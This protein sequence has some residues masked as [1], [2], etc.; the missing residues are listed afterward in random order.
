MGD[1]MVEAQDVLHEL[2]QQGRPVEEYF[3]TFEVH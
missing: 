2:K 1:R 3:D